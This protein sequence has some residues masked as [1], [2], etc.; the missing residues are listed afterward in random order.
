M[1]TTGTWSGDILLRQVDLGVGLLIAACALAL[2]INRG[3]KT[4][5][6][7]VPTTR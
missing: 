5:G 1:W 3:L 6:L 4:R 7:I 2:H